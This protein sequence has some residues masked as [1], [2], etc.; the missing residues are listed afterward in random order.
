MATERK[1]TNKQTNKQTKNKTKQKKPSNLQKKGLLYFTFPHR[2]M[3]NHFSKT[4]QLFTL[5]L[6]I[7][8]MFV[9]AVL[10]GG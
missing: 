5:Q 2:T 4:P 9:F 3:R 6:S 1:K 10:K 8:V 7:H